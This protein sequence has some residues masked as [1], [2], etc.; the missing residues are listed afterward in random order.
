MI[1]FKVGDKTYEVRFGYG[2]LSESDV[3][4]RVSEMGNVDPQQP[5]GMRQIVSVLP[6]LLLAGLQ[7]YHKDSFGY[8]T[9]E[10][11][12]VAFHKVCDLLDDYEEESTEENPKT[13][14]DLFAKLNEELMKN[15]FLSGAQNSVAQDQMKKKD[16]TVVPMDHKKK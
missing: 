5:G 7:K 13:G 15:G 16:A 6:D 8:E 1:T 10:E 12:N 9:D 4:D 14:Y 2:V 11:K 3:L